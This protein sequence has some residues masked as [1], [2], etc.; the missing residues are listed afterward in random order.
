VL[1]GGLDVAR[2][3][4]LAPGIIAFAGKGNRASRAIVEDA[5][6]DLADLIAAAVAQAGLAQDAPRIALAGGLLREPSLLTSLLDARL[7][8]VLPGCAIEPANLGRSA[9]RAALRFAHALAAAPA[10]T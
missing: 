2:I 1:A 10:S 7:A 8:L 6:R 5:A 3:A 9:E 4:S